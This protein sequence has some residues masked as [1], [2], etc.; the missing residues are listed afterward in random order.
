MP[1]KL[2]IK[3]YK[4]DERLNIN[5][6]CSNS[7]DVFFRNDFDKILTKNGNDKL[8]MSNTFWNRLFDISINAD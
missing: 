1:K 7:N 5:D 4:V 8:M 2:I 3:H 6:F